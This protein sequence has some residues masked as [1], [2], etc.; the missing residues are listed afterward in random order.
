[1]VRDYSNEIRLDIDGYDPFASYPCGIITLYLPS[2]QAL[3]GEQYL[4]VPI[5]GVN[6]RFR[7]RLDYDYDDSDR[8]I[9]N[10]EYLGCSR[11]DP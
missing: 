3:V 11:D 8:L 1:M 6:H 5:H 9:W 2:D 4:V 10:A 7:F